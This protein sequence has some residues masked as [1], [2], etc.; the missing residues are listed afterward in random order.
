MGDVPQEPYLRAD[1]ALRSN[2][3]PRWVSSL[4][5]NGIEVMEVLGQG[6]YLGHGGMGHVIGGKIRQEV[7]LEAEV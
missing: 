4:S 7:A 1:V 3:A 5:L 6:A 2:P